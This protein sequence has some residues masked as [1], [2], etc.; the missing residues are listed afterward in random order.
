MMYDD[1]FEGD[2]SRPGQNYNIQ[3]V[4]FAAART[5]LTVIARNPRAMRMPWAGR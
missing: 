5:Y 2:G 3:G 4:S 1:V